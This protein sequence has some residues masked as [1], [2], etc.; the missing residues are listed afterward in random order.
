MS[1]LHCLQCLVET[2]IAVKSDLDPRVSV[3][4]LT[5]LTA[6][7]FSS[8]RP[9]IDRILAILLL[10]VIVRRSVIVKVSIT[11]VVL[12]HGLRI[13]ATRSRTLLHSR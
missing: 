4:L 13:A 9:K 3:S 2:S 8:L 12:D 6:S 5:C 1:P 10:I 7:S 11:F